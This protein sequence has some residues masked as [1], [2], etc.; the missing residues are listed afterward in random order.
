MSLG[1]QAT[2]EFPMTQFE[3]QST[4]FRTSSEMHRAIAD[5]YMSAGGANDDET[6]RSFLSECSDAELT[7]EC[8]QEWE[9]AEFDDDGDRSMPDYNRA[10]L[11][12]AFEDLR[13][14]HR[15]I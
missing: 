3:F 9:L 11:R 14:S 13:Q 12:E 15:L 6:I 7:A 5:S 2:G 4:L 10:E 8:E 1:N